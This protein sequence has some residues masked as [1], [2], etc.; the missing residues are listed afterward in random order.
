MYRDK[1]RDNTLSSGQVICGN[2]LYISQRRFSVSNALLLKQVVYTKNLT[3][4]KL[5]FSILFFF[6]LIISHGHPK[7][8]YKF[9]FFVIFIIV[10]VF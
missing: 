7:F 4:G 6:A 10:T 8:S 2:Y 3:T 1:I 9:F 5:S